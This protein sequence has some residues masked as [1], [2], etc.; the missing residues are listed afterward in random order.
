MS[1]CG[2]LR[3][4][5]LTLQWANSTE[6]ADE[7]IAE[8]RSFGVPVEVRAAPGLP[9]RWRVMRALIAHT[10]PATLLDVGGFGHYNDTARRARCLNIHPHRGCDVYAAGSRLPYR[11]GRFSTVLLETVLHHAAEDTLQLL[12]ESARVARRY[13]IVAEDVL[14]RRA[15]SNV[16]ASY[17]AHDPWAV[18]R[19]T[20]EW[21]TLARG[22]GLVLERIVALDRVPLHVAREARPRCTLDYPPMQYMVFRVVMH[23]ARAF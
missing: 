14:D 23:Q 7:A 22:R 20:H 1:A 12:A 15:S 19:S 16:V 5:D 3:Y 4:G 6:T 11:T 9:G 13:V 8:L 21:V 18:Y 17:R 10:N 2:A